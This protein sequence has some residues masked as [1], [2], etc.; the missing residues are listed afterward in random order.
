MLVIK[1]VFKCV[2]FPF[3]LVYR[4]IKFCFKIITSIFRR[5]DPVHDIADF[6]SLDE[7]EEPI[8]KK[9]TLKSISKIG[10]VV[11]TEEDHDLRSFTI[12]NGEGELFRIDTS[13]KGDFYG[14][15][16]TKILSC[17]ETQETLRGRIV[18]TIHENGTT[19]GFFVHIG[20]AKAYLSLVDSMRNESQ[21]P[22]NTL[23]A[24]VHIDPKKAQATVSSRVA[25]ARVFTNEPTP[26]QGEK[27]RAIYW[28]Y[29]SKY[30]YFLL[31]KN[32]M[33]VAEREEYSPTEIEKI[34]GTIINCNINSIN[35]EL[36]EAKVTIISV[37]N[38]EIPQ[39][40]LSDLMGN[41][42]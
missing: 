15:V 28:D 4:I 30:I 5:Q 40:E 20:K 8:Y 29:D 10:T 12:M 35:A 31:P 9:P 11:P 3:Y 25:Y 23:F 26:C 2:F 37:E 33:G 14:S 6:N 13:A 18:N 34:M 1:Y 41:E 16:W 17:Y 21:A 38:T 39:I 36:S 22:I 24:V 7:I 32:Y 42:Q 27:T 19:K